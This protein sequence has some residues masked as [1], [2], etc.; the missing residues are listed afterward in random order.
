MARTLSQEINASF[1]GSVLVATHAFVKKIIPG[2]NLRKDAWTYRFDGDHFEFQTVERV[3]V[4]EKFYWSG[5][6]YNAAEARAEG[7]MAYLKKFHRE[8]YDEVA[9]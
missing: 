1:T 4:I 7:W 2:V 9:L 8:A 3:G 6:A 5:T